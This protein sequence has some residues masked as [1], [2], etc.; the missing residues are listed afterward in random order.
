MEFEVTTEE[1]EVRLKR[2]VATLRPLYGVGERVELAPIVV[3]RDLDGLP[4]CY[5]NHSLYIPAF[6]SLD[7]F[8]YFPPCDESFFEACKIY[9][10]FPAH[11]Y[12]F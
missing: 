12:S 5:S 9:D 11:F 2:I 1:L 4:D 10:W 8:F 7:G 6:S 3:R